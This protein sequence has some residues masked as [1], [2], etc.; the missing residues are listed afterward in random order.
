LLAVTLLQ[1]L[2]DRLA[3]WR[4]EMPPL[5]ESAVARH[6]RR[7]GWNVALKYDRDIALFA[8]HES[9]GLFGVC[10]C[11]D[12]PSH[13]LLVRLPQLAAAHHVT[14]LVLSGTEPAR[15]RLDTALDKGVVLMTWPDLDGLA[16][17]VRRVR[18]H[19]EASLGVAKRQRDPRPPRPSRSI[20]LPLCEAQRAAGFF[21]QTEHVSCW[22]ADRGGDTLLATFAQWGSDPERPTRWGEGY[23]RAAGLS[24][25]GFETSSPNW[26]PEEDMREC[27]DAAESLLGTRFPTRLLVG[28]SQGGHAALRHGAALRATAVLAVS[29]AYSIDPVLF[30]DGRF[31]ARYRPAL[32]SGMHV[33]AGDVAGRV[34]VVFDPCDADDAGHAALL[35][36][37][38]AALAPAPILLPLAFCGHSSAHL[39]GADTVLALLGACRAGDAAAL[40]R[41][42]AQARRH[43]MRAYLM[44]LWLAERR[45]ATAHALFLRHRDAPPG[46]EWRHVCYRLAQAGWGGR[47]LGWLGAVAAAEPGNAELLVSLALVAARAGAPEQARAAILAALRLQPEDERL[48]HVRDHVLGLAGPA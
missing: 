20:A 6:F 35:G 31:G 30:R 11:P 17:Q 24:S 1:P 41:V 37:A 43:P 2:A 33:A 3:A 15:D 7:Q 36:A 16:E 48:A 29:P 42:A 27:L 45:P 34:A 47:V 23:G 32:N 9:L 26:F 40:R 28:A 5:T 38:F 10:L 8:R 12:G 21:F 4:G 44:A 25:L 39:L 14:V 19:A 13:S 46:T 18:A 22:F